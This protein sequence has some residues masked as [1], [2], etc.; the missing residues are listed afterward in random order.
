MNEDVQFFRIFGSIFAGIGSLFAAI[1]IMT[2]VSTH[3]F[4][5]TSILTQGTVI[6]LV[7]RLSTDS[8][9]NSSFLYHPVVRFTTNSGEPTIFEAGGSNPPAFT[10]GQQVEVRYSPQNP[11][12]ASIDSWF[13]LW[14]LP[15][16]ITST[17]LVFVLIGGI[18]LI[19][20]FP[21]LMK[22]KS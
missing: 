22:Y 1:G 18:V 15:V 19:K 14:F 16:I 6:T 17:S 10:L 4:V 20:S 2:G 13:E 5:N 11:K 21:R 9:G 12:E 8:D 7:E 3:S